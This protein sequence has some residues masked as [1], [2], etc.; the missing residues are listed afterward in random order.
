[1]GDIGDACEVFQG[2]CNCQY[3][4]ENAPTS[5]TEIYLTVAFQYDR[6]LKQSSTR[7]GASFTNCENETIS[8]YKTAFISQ[9]LRAFRAADLNVHRNHMDRSSVMMIEQF[10]SDNK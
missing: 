1:M 4:Q 10:S 5:T 7:L 9:L 2:P 6:F 8:F 3:Q